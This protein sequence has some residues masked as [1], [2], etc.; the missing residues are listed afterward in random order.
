MNLEN[1]RVSLV[2][3]IY[4]NKHH[5]I[6]VARVISNKNKRSASSF[7]EPVEVKEDSIK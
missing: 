2:K 4:S 3:Q 6:H 1:K 5:M 7:I